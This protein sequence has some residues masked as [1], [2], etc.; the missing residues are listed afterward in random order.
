MRRAAI[1]FSVFTCTA[2]AEP[3]YLFTSFRGNG[4]TGVF[5]AESNDG[6]TWTPA[7]K[8]QP[9]I[10]PSEPGMLMRDPWLGKGPDGTWHLLWTWGWT[11]SAEPHA[12][13]KLGHATSRDLKN[14]SAQQAIP[15]L[16]ADPLARNAWAPE[17]VYIAAKKQWIIFWATTSSRPDAEYDHRLYSITTAD[18]QTFTPAKPFFDPGFSAID[19]TIVKVGNRWLM[20]FK[21]ERKTPLV[22]KLRLA[23]ATSPEGPWTHVSEPFTEAWVEGPTVLKL[24]N[25]W[26][27]YF[28]HYTKPQHYGALR[29]RDWQH[30]EDM[31]A[32]VHFPEGQ[33]HGTAVR[34]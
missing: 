10:R 33:R 2:L 13:L 19:S 30:F 17:A 25:W 32:A 16:T 7:N 28:D 22:K 14:W 9:I 34:R 26:W 29:T 3:P 6:K 11:K 20:V 1:L 18:W 8:A 23:R 21:D 5:L 27:L 31:T 24:G 15:V 4:E 12:S